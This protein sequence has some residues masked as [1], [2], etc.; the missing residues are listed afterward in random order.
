MTE[1][2]DNT[3]SIAPIDY[4][5]R[6]RAIVDARHEQGRRLDSLHSRPDT[7]GGERA[8]RFARYVE[9]TGDDDPLLRLALPVIDQTKT[10]LD[11][12][13]GPGRHALPLARKARSVVAVES[14]ASMRD[15]LAASIEREGLTNLTVVPGSWPGVIPSVT[16]AD[17]VICSHVV[18]GV[19]DID[20]FVRGLTSATRGRCIM[21][22]RHSQREALFFDLFAQVWGEPRVG[23]PTYLDLY[24]VLVQ[25]GILANVEMIPFRSP[26][27][28][29]SEDEAI[30]QVFAEILNPPP[31]D[32]ERPV[33][34]FVRD[35][36]SERN[37]QLNFD[38]PAASSA[39]IWWDQDEAR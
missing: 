4:I 35:H 31:A 29:D 37:G 2:P 15:H 27:G 34:R 18:Y 3:V 33:R 17:L 26:G 9:E 20:D 7:W 30:A 12:G 25:M 23:H 5:A 1:Q 39:L 22:L 8:Q 24:G 10:V 14:S 16:Q 21:A 11:V 38:W 36:L 6:W 32:A 19:V 28:F 13:A